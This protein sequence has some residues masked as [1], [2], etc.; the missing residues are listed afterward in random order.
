MASTGPYRSDVK[1]AR[2]ALIAQGKNL[3]TDTVRVAL[4]NSGSKTTIYKYLK[5]LDEDDSGADS[6]KASISGA[7][8]LGCALG[9]AVT[10]RSESSR[11]T[12]SKNRAPTRIA[13]VPRH[14]PDNCSAPRSTQ[15]KKRRRT[16]EPAKLCKARRSLGIRWSS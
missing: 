14:W 2:D 4:G 6:R 3:S 10:G 8:R 7:E 16:H 5:E 12:R 15:P 11:R 13:S 1:K 9:R